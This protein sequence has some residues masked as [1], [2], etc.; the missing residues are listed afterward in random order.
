MP[1]YHS[2][3][4]CNSLYLGI[5]KWGLSRLQLIQNAAVCI[6]MS[7]I[8]FYN[9][10]FYLIYFNS[11]NL[12][13]LSLCSALCYINKVDLTWHSLNAIMTVQSFLKWNKAAAIRLGQMWQKVG[14][15]CW[16]TCN[17]CRWKPTSVLCICF[18]WRLCW[19]AHNES[20]TSRKVR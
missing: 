3:G 11:F 7:H 12:I 13:I 5:C 20:Q 15:W 6:W 2:L 17:T 16:N 9:V 14:Y 18:Q 19:W 1:S 8:H 10:F 4:Y